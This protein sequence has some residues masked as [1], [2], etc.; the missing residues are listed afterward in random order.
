MSGGGFLL[1]ANMEK[2][3]AGESTVG[4]RNNFHG[5]ISSASINVGT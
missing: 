1:L 2:K 4:C 3:D 5:G